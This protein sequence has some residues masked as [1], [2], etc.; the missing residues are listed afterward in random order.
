[1]NTGWS[2][3]VEPILH[4]VVATV[5]DDSLGV[6]PGLQSDIFEVVNLSFRQR[7]EVWLGVVGWGAEGILVTGIDAFSQKT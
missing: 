2:Y 7:F 4:G 6:V 3:A 5:D 1:M